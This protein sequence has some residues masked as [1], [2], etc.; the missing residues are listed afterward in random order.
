MISQSE[1][2]KISSFASEDLSRKTR[3][4]Q[5]EL[6][7]FLTFARKINPDINGFLRYD[8]LFIDGDIYHYDQVTGNVE[9]LRWKYNKI[10]L[11]YQD[12]F[13]IVF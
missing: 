10:N 12:I 8:R 2:N 11:F 5:Q 3:E 9:L 13:I 7:K 1:N 4:A 6:R